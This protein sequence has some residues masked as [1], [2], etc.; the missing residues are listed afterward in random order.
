MVFF[1]Y[2]LQL[3]VS[4]EII[5]SY[6]PPAKKMTEKEYFVDNAI[7][8]SLLVFLTCKSNSSLFLVSIYLNGDQSYFLLLLETRAR[9]ASK[10][11]FSNVFLTF[12]HFSIEI[13]SAKYHNMSEIYS[14]EIFSLKLLCLDVFVLFFMACMTC[15]IFDKSRTR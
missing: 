6:F 5:K 7:L 12:C 15:Y 2:P 13:C 8:R 1:T 11:C 9:Y 4:V 14:T 10:Q 3:L